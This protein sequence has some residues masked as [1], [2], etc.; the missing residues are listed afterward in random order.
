VIE[1]PSSNLDRI[2]LGAQTFRDAQL[3]GYGPLIMQIPIRAIVKIGS[4]YP[5][6]QSDESLYY[7][8]VNNPNRMGISVMYARR[9]EDGDD[10]GIMA[11]HVNEQID[12]LVP[13]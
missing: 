12:L 4:A 9:R 2:L 3:V 11:F 6:R 13:N 7:E 5:F 8:G 1:S 10:E